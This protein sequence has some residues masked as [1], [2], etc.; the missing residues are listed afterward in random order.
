MKAKPAATAAHP[1]SYRYVWIALAVLLILLAVGALP[2]WRM[3]QANYGPM[4]ATFSQCEICGQSRSVATICG[5]RVR[6]EISPTDHSKWLATFV[7][8]NHKHVWVAASS[9]HRE[10]WFGSTVIAC[11][12]GG[13]LPA[14]H[15]Q[16]SK[17]SED[18][19]RQLVEKY[20]ELLR[21]PIDGKDRYEQV[22]DFARAMREDPES[23][24]GK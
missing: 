9:T 15:A 7:P 24:L 19:C 20:H 2:T 16:R 4:S 22:N 23:L 13:I 10:E 1:G 21:S 14:I 6:D 12:I 3:L 17:I 5:R 11:G 8:A 18:E